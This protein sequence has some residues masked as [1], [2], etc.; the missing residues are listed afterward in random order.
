MKKRIVAILFT[1]MSVL[2]V[3][4]KIQCILTFTPSPSP[5][6]SGYWFYWRSATGTYAD[7]QRKAVGTN[8]FV[9]FDLRTIGLSKGEYIVMMTATN[10]AGMESDPSVEVP[11][12]YVNPGKPSNLVIKVP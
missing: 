8:D 11:W 2:A 9:G 1:A 10:L 6:A 12:H 3:G 4:P 5:D 7:V